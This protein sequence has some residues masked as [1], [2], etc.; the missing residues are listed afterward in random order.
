MG[1]LPKIELFARQKIKGW[2]IWG[3]ELCND[4]NMEDYK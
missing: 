1:E 3:N 2:D 4:I